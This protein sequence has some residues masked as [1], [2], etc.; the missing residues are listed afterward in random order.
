MCASIAQERDQ[1]SFD[2]PT[3][4][5]GASRL[6]SPGWYPDPSGRG[7]KRYW[8][9]AAWQNMTL[10]AEG[11][12]QLPPMPAGRTDVLVGRP[13]LETGPIEPRRHHWTP[14]RVL[15]LVTVVLLGGCGW[16]AA[17]AGIADLATGGDVSALVV[18]CIGIAVLLGWAAVLAVI[19]SDHD[20]CYSL[21]A[22]RRA[23]RLVAVAW[24][25]A[26]VVGVVVAIVA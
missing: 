21:Q 8:D 6:P 18:G 11:L 12:P 13:M 4:E 9:G 5:G 15:E 10:P 19:Y 26:L 14:G 22:P 20:R 2:R 23:W 17:A 25:S 1:A 16:G 3:V 7:L 24:L